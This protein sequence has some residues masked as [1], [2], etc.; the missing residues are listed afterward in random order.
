MVQV[1]NGE[2]RSLADASV[3]LVTDVHLRG[4]SRNPTPL[5]TLLK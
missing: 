1:Y 3:C 4:D 5:K 2:E